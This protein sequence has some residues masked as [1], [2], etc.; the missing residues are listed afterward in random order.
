MQNNIVLNL[1]E[2]EDEVKSEQFSSSTMAY[3][4]EEN[5]GNTDLCVSFKIN[6][7][8]LDDTNQRLYVNK[9][10]AY[11]KTYAEVQMFTHG[12]HLEGKR[13]IPHIHIHFIISTTIAWT[14]IMT[15][16]SQHRKRWFDQQGYEYPTG[17][18]IEMKSDKVDPLQ[19]KWHFLAY[20]MKEGK[21]FN[22]VKLFE[23]QIEPMTTDMRT[24]LIKYAKKIYDQKCATDLANDRCEE[25]KEIKYGEILKAA[26][27]FN[28]DTFRHF[29]IYMEDE[30]IAKIIESGDNIPDIENYKKNLKRA[31]VQLKYFKTY[32]I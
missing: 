25:R 7:P 15:N 10:I 26:R 28:G 3:A 14:R 23:F 1:S 31:A 22:N 16:A 20:P 4:F 13:A 19:P 6:I 2:I 5:I 30:Y 27:N 9:I 21:Y 18:I 8:N 32:E 12:I 17:K 29:Q 11:M 24:F